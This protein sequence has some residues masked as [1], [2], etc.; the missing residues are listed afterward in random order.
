MMKIPKVALTSE[1]V[2]LLLLLKRAEI[3]IETLLQKVNTSADQVRA[4][5]TLKDL[6][7]M[8]KESMP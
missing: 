2:H 4:L 3:D 5:A 6:Q 8:F 1:N 7:G